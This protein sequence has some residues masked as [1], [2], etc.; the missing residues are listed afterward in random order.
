MRQTDASQ[1]LTARDRSILREI[2]STFLS[3]GEPVSSRSVAKRHRQGL[4]PAT[5][6]NVMADLEDLGYLSQPHTSAGRVPT[7]SGYHLYI[8]SLMPS[9]LVSA[10]ARR[11]IDEHLRQATQNGDQLVAV[12]TQLLSELSHLIGIVITPDMG[13]TVIKALNFVRLS[14]KRVHCILVSENGFVDHKIIETKAEISEKELLRIS[15]YLTHH[16]AGLTLK[17]IRDRLLDMMADARASV[18]KLLASAIALGHEAVREEAVPSLLVEG[19]AAVLTQPELADLDMIRRL[20]DTF[21]DKAKLVGILNQLIEGKGVRVVIGEDS[22]LT[23]NLEF[24]LVATTY[25]IKEKSLGSLGIF[26]PSRMNYPAVIPLVDY[27]GERLSLAL[28]STMSD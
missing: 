16:F 25:G 4:S 20:L 22:D 24:S 7:D 19:T 12:A 26:G 15:N 6:R 11:Y 17:E 13:E 21:A 28:E 14:G 2:I 5:V 8:D 23:S 9:R 3:S 27:L 1:Q 10:Q 18:D